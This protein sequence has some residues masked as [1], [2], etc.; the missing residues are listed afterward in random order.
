MTQMYPLNVV[1]GAYIRPPPQHIWK[2]TLAKSHE[3]ATAHS[4]L[5]S[6]C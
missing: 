6:P 5:S 1:V 2:V 4:A 3:P